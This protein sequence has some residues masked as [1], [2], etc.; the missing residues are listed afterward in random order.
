MTWQAIAAGA[1]GLMYYSFG[2]MRRQFKP[3]EFAHHWTYVK[4]VVDEVAKHI[5]ILL[6]DG[7]PPNVEGATAAVPVRAWR[8]KDEVWLLAVNTLR[9]AQTVTLSVAGLSAKAQKLQVAFG[10]APEITP[11]GKLSFTFKPLEQ[12]LLRLTGK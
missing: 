10:P 8:N 3:D 7:L 11:D 4:A 12:T 9:K 2:A 1:N 5:P 6:S